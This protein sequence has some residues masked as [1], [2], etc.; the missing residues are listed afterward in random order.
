L[1]HESAAGEALFL[2]IGACV[3]LF[4]GGAGKFS[5]DAVIEHARHDKLDTKFKENNHVST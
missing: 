1:T 4:F 3:A 5:V 2:Y